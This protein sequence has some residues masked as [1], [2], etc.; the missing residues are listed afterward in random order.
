MVLKRGEGA[1]YQKKMSMKC[2]LLTR[3]LAYKFK[4]DSNR[5]AAA[6]LTKD[7]E[8]GNSGTSSALRANG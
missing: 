7:V 6:V 5:P 2:S 1:D 8:W 4:N 3:E